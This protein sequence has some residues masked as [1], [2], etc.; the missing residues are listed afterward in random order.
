MADATQFSSG[1]VGTNATMNAKN[2]DPLSST[3]SRS[4]LPW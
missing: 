4:V 2:P 1:R 3:S